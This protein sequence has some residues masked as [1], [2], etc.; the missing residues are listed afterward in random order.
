[1]RAQVAVLLILRTCAPNLVLSCGLPC[2]QTGRIHLLPPV[3]RPI[4]TPTFFWLF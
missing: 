4:P 2:P 3:A 1:M